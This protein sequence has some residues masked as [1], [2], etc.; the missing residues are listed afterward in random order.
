MESISH[1]LR[2][3]F[4]KD[5]KGLVGIDSRVG[6]LMSLLAIGSNDVFFVGI[7]GMG[8]IGKTTLARVVYDKVFNEFQGGCFIAN[9]RS[10]SEK[11]GLLPLQQ[12]LIREIL[13]EES[14]N[15]RD[16]YDGIDIIKNR[17]CHKK[18]L[19]VLDDVN[20][21][22]Q[23]EKLVGDSRWFG[24]G[25]R[26]IITT[27]DEHLIRH[28]VHT[29]Y[30]AQGMNDIEALC[31]FS[32][33]AFK[34][35]DPPKDYLA[36]S[37]SFIDYA[38]GLPLAIDVLGSFLYDR[39]KEEWEGTLNRLKEY[40]NKKIIEILEIGFDG[41]EDI[42]KEIFL[43]IACFFNMKGNDY[44]VEIL[45]CLGLHPK[46]GLKVL[47]ERSLLNYYGNIYW[48]HDVLQQM[49][50]DM[51]RRDCPLEPEK[52]S[53]LWLYKDIRSVLMK[54]IVRDCL[55]NYTLS[56]YSKKLKFEQL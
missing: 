9:V 20:Q 3:R 1:K 37:K 32:L 41:L 47:I 31:L 44:I 14:V 39:S 56:C 10:E 46:I 22:N 6:D 2:Y 43:H 19:L 52:W 4:P 25:S 49:G 48:M 40:P 35:Y 53:K 55:E 11:C 29:I 12:K 17:L 42:E 7:W 23:L 13:M 5:T 30:E 16:D 24:R 18:I 8:G 15:I 33:K 36:L 38:K 21:F 34:E 50:Q 45:D 51:V 54:N 27:R 28:K 26:V